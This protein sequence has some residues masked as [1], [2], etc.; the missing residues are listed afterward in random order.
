MWDRT[1][2]MLLI[3]SLRTK[4]FAGFLSTADNVTPNTFHV[5][6]KFVRF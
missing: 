2:I 5:S 1:E 6:V 3:A 4:F